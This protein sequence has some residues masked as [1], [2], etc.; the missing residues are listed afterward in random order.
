MPGSWLDPNAYSTR[1]TISTWNCRTRFWT[2]PSSEGL[3]L[4]FQSWKTAICV[5]SSLYTRRPHRRPSFSRWRTT[6]PSESPGR[7]RI[8]L[9][10]GR[11]RAG[12]PLQH[13]RRRGRNPN[14]SERTAA[15]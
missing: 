4:T 13:T 2:S 3:F 15:R 1:R 11:T 10:H 8:L 5:P 14:S 9:A 7:Q 12:V 6:M